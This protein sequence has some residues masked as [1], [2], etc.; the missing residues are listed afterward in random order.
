[1]KSI[2]ERKEEKE[3]QAD[4]EARKKARERQIA[5]NKARNTLLNQEKNLKEQQ[6]KWIEQ[7]KQAIA[8][9]LDAMVRK[10]KDGIKYT[11]A[12]YY[13][14]VCM[15]LEMESALLQKEV[16][17]TT[18][19]FLKTVK[20]I[21]EDIL[22]TKPEDVIAVQI[23]L[24]KAIEKVRG[25]SEALDEMLNSAQDNNQLSYEENQTDLDNYADQLLYGNTETDS[26]LSNNI[27]NTLEEIK[28]KI[29]S[30]K[31]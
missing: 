20:M 27:D 7:G 29:N 4:M 28:K 26:M 24:E 30:I 16:M 3:K 15:R 14:V 11:Q 31:E 8:S 25:Q 2:K 1:M 19:D 21:S 23:Q 10:A 6:K 9:G 13:Q 18:N 17:G 5:I 12:K 22:D